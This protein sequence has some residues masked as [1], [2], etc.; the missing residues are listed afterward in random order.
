MNSIFALLRVG[1]IPRRRQC[2]PTPIS[3]TC[4]GNS[5]DGGAWKATV[6]GVT[7]KLDTTEKLTLKP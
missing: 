7:K 2:P 5:T 1:N 3:P 6:H 4:P